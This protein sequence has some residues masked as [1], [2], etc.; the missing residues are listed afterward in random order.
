MLRGPQIEMTRRLRLS[1]GAWRR[2]AKSID[3]RRSRLNWHANLTYY[4]SGIV[5]SS[6]LRLQNASHSDALKTCV[7]HP[8]VFVLG[9]WRSGTTLLHELFCCDPQ[10]GFPSTYACL[11]PSHFLLTEAWTRARGAQE[12][13]R[14]MDNM[15]YSWA[16]PQEDE[17]ALLAL[18]A[19]SCYEALIV[20]SLMREPGVLLDVRQRPPEEQKRWVDAF[21]SFLRLLTV[22]QGKTIV[23]KSPSHGFKLPL[24]LSMFP[25]ARYVLI[26]RNPYEVFASNVKLWRTLLDLYALESSSVEEIE[27]F[28]L[29]AY[30]M[31]EEAISEGLDM[32]GLRRFAF[33]RYEDLVVDPVREM[34]RLYQELNLPDFDQVQWRMEKHTRAVAGHTRNRFIVS[35][36]QKARIENF[37]GPFIKTKNYDWPDQ[38][39]RTEN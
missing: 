22:Q 27:K 34:K 31:Y 33:V 20:P 13:T 25:D 19:P 35:S 30:I 23:F 1:L 12:T 17:F 32:A 8:P 5:H 16:S 18:G 26:E 38:Y 15:S 14:P 3:G 4:L 6:L 39:L 7:S 28:V 2:L 37:W 36:P 29:E 24:L 9:F 21:Q 11:N 10:F